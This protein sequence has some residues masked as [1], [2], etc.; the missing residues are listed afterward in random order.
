MARRTSNRRNPQG[1][2]SG[3]YRS[4]F[5]RTIAEHLAALGVPVRYEESVIEY[6]KKPAKYTP[7]F[8]LPNGILIEAKG[9][10]LSSDRSKHLLIKQQHPHLDIRFVFQNPRVKLNKT[11]KTTYADW[12]DRH[13]FLWA[14][15]RVPDSWLSQ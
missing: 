5:E 14:E 15:K 12:C 6:Q 10:F 11:S 1:Q 9:R 8:E 2:R 13:G 3:Q 7:D 4:K